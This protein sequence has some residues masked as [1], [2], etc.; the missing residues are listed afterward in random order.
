MKKLTW[1]AAVAVVLLF[2]NVYSFRLGI[3]PVLWHDDFEYTYPSFSLAQH[4][5][6]GSPLL[7]T[8]L[9][10]HD[11]TYNLIVY[12]Y[13]CVHAVLI[14]L[15]GAG[16]D[17]IPLANTLHFALLAA[18]G[19]FLLLR[20][21]A[22]LGACLFL[23]ALVR[24]G[25]MVEAARH[26][27][28]E[29]TAGFCLTMGVIGLWLWF[30]EG[31]RSP[32]L[33]PAT[34][35]AL[36]A[37]MLSHTATVFFVIA[38]AAAF[39]PSLVRRARAQDA[40]VGA[41]PFLAI[42]LLYIY[43]FLTDAHFAANFRGQL[44][45][46]E[47][48]VAIGPL[49][50]LALGGEWRELGAIV[51]DFVHDHAG[52]QALWLSLPACLLLPR[53]VPSSLARA[54]RFFAFVYLLL[55]LVNFLCLK[56]IVPWYRDIYQP[57][58]YLSCAMLAEVVFQLVSGW[59]VRPAWTGAL[60]LACA[61]LVVALIA[62]EVVAFRDGLLGQRL[63]YAQLKGALVYALTESGARPGDRVFAPSPFGFHLAPTFDVIAYPAPRFYRGR[64]SV[65]FRES[66]RRVWGSDTIA[67]VPAEQLCDAMGLAFVRPSWVISWDGD[68]SSVQPF[69]R[70]LR[71]YPDLPGMRVTRLRSATL[72]AVYGG[73]VR[74]YR[75]DF[76]A[77]MAGLDRTDHFEEQPCP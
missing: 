14:R 25:T 41:L 35:A 74:V 26:G 9:G 75:L 50:L 36:T 12:Y 23:Y 68:M 4:G 21:H 67:R 46:A 76:D 27:R 72:P 18:A 15:Y 63:P 16:P 13:A 6:L 24:D 65:A 60:R 33:L 49:A 44:A 53:V 37:G 17:A 1:A 59:L 45:P 52:P 39:A 30:G 69:Y 66:V 10:I 7:G 20:R 31:G 64:W 38:L 77:S 51:R 43:F 62:R 56:H 61:A 58:G 5:N 28:P 2:F 40:V 55:F 34:S 71:I 73:P 42:P 22:P 57:I 3:K 32:M 47:G 29:M 8:A 54:A 48:G 19:A 70:F 11:R